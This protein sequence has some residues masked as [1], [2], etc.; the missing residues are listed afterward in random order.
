[1]PRNKPVFPLQPTAFPADSQSGEFAESIALPDTG[2]G[3]LVHLEEAEERTLRHA[4]MNWHQAQA[5]ELRIEPWNETGH[6]DSF[7]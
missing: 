7:P 5:R 3:L 2:W 6:F 1:M 4:R